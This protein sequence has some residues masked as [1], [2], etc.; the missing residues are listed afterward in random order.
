MNDTD[1]KEEVGVV[2]NI[3]GVQWIAKRSISAWVPLSLSLS[4]LSTDDNNPRTLYD[5]I[6]LPGKQACVSDS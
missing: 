5:L 4:T 6:A 1:T 3:I 2:V